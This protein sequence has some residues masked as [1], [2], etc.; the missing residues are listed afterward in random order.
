MKSSGFLVSLRYF[1]LAFLLLILPA[2]TSQAQ[3]YIFG[4][5][6]FAVGTVPTS[7]AAGDF[8]GDG[9]TDLVVTNNNDKTVSVLLRRPDATF[10]PQ[11]TYATSQ[12]PIAVVVGDFNGDGNLDLAVTNENCTGTT[13]L[14]VCSPS[15]V[16]ILLGNGDGTFQTHVDYPVGALPSSLVAADFNGDG[17]LDLAVANAYDST[18]SVLPGNGDGTFQPQV[19]YATAESSDWQSVV[20]GDFN[21]DGKLDLAVSC[22]S[23]VSVLLGNG[24]GTFK[25]HLDSGAGG[26]SLAAG[27]FNG[28][29]KLDLAVN[30]AGVGALL[31]VLLGNGDGTF[32]ATQQY[33]GGSA[34]AANDLRGNGI[35]DLIVSSAGG[36]SGDTY[37]SIAVLLGNGDGTF[38]PE[39]HYG[40]DSAPG[41][42]SGSF[43]VTDLNGDGKLDVAVADCACNV[44]L[45]PGNISVLLGFGDGTFVGKSDYGAGG[46]PSTL[47]AA[48]FNNDGHL[49][50]ATAN[51]PP[52]SVSVLLGNANGTF[53][54]QV[55]YP[56]GTL[57]QSVAAA[58]LRNNG[59]VDLITANKVC[60]TPPCTPG[61]VSVLLGH[62]DGT[63]QTHVDYAAG[64]EPASVAVGD[65]RSNGT[66]DLAV[67]NNGSSSVSILLGNGDGTFQ[68][69]VSYL[70]VPSPEQIAIGDFNGDG[71]LDLA[72]VGPGNFSILLGNGDGTFQPQVEYSPGGYSITTADFNGDG[73]LDLALGNEGVSI[74]LGNGDGTFQ[75]PVTFAIAGATAFSIAVA[76]FNQDG[77][78]DLALSTDSTVSAI[79]LGNG[80]GTFQ[81]PIGYLL[82]NYISDWL[83]VGD[84]NGDDVPDLAAGDGD[85]DTIGVMLSTPFKAISPGSLNFG[86]QGVGTTSVA[87]TI[88]ITNPSN[89][90][91][92][93]ASIAATGKFNQS[94]NCVGSLAIGAHCSVNVTFTP[95]ATGALSGAITMTDNTKISPLAIPLSGAGV[96]GPF[97]TLF[98]SR[99]NFSVENQ[100]SSSSPRAVMLVNTGN[101]ALSISNISIMG[102]DASDFSLKTACSSSLAPGASC[103]VNVTFTPKASG[104][105]TAHI[106]VS[107][108]APGSP[109][110][111]MLSGTG[112][113]TAADFA[114]S[115]ASG[116]SNSV[117]ITAGQTASFN[118]TVTPAGSFSGTVNLSCAITPAVTPA[119]ICAVAPSV[120]VTE[121]TA[122]AVTVKISTTAP[123]MAG[124]I[125][126]AAVPPRIMPV[127]WAIFLLAPGFLLFGCRR[128]M[129]ALAIPTLAVVLLGMAACGGGGGSGSKKTP[130]SPAG[131]YSAMVTAKSGSLS[132]STT[133]TVM[134]Q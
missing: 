32:V 60:V 21:G 129:P 74:L 8:N 46:R 4:R 30:G 125:S 115:P 19:V 132:H 48:D 117:T 43:A 62:G 102:A 45:V 65:F 118:L 56:V 111:I 68:P 34:V 25:P 120:N 94:N 87:Q 105:R 84:F 99:V 38:Q 83:T 93:V 7:V 92:N 78:L 133:L 101:A 15:T 113:G 134:V 122:A 81:Q 109:Q 91:I 97:L 16:S 107:D 100:G 89:V 31:T 14:L 29:G 44:Q 116:S 24:D 106:S 2:P 123:G 55:S 51:P 47:T 103:N 127:T 66:L 71:K 26:V 67:A 57:P 27:D 69:Q 88:T 58:D 33:L 86:S 119:P 121:G 28:D 3:T 108:S 76:D 82:A 124:S 64:L 79:M 61:S 80:D 22:G 52:N 42:S 54:P 39:V 131:T 104:S 95:T 9:L 35:L 73:K 10:A 49:D 96:N 63:F 53:Q 13:P 90:K 75:A 77:K 72:V 85:G 70:T 18:V 20:A 114:I 36:P 37:N 12:N 130:G 5:A 126:R 41:Q 112:T 6:D 128:R 11:V 23:A 1:G 59:D 50:L 110:M 98:P 17:K 40:T